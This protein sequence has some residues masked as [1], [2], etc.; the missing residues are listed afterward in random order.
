[1]RMKNSGKK[2]RG[3]ALIMITLSLIPMFGLLGLVVDVGWMEFI[4]KQAQ[5][6]ADAAAMAALLQFQ[7][8][9]F[10]S[11]LTCGT[12]G[13][14]CQAPTSCSPAPSNYLNSGCLYAQLNGFSSAGNQFVTI[15]A[16]VGVPPTAAGVQSS[17]YWVTVRV[18][19]AVPQLFSAVL[20]NSSGL[21]SARATAALSP[22]RDCIYV[23][24]PSGSG[25]L[26]MGGTSDLTTSC[27]VYVNSNSPT[28]LSG[29]GTPTLTASEIDIV[30]NYLYTGTLNPNPPS[31]SV[32]PMNDPFASLPA[33][34]VPAGCDYN[35]YQANGNRTLS[36]GVY[37]GGID[38][39]NS[40]TTMNPGTYIIKGGGLTTQSTNSILTG[41]GVTIYNT[42]DATH[43]YGALN[44]NANS[45]VTLAAP[46]TGTYAGVLIMED[47][48]IGAGTYTDNFGGGSQQSYTGIIYAPKSNMN[49]F[50]NA[51]SSAY[52]ILVSYRLQM[53]GTSRINNDYSSLPTGNPI[54]VTALVE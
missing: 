31:T 36:P 50:G 30:G 13:V 46:T 44:I 5:T 26:S 8:T 22:A 53:V 23:M 42:Y 45:T 27:G 18:N 32:A 10:S 21:V 49:Y 14:V 3:Q 17:A 37:C 54:K 12:N 29:N 2:R 35:N 25:A 16:G 9:T 24:D 6:A 20:G 4:K 51:S 33:P 48:S 40:T 41:N 52:T 1:M 39:R 28:A 15:Q 43:P 38:I 11:D 34:T 47:R 7:S 19:Q